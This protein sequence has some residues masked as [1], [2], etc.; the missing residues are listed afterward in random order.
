MKTLK[1]NQRTALS[2]SALMILISASLAAAP[3]QAGI[4]FGVRVDTPVVKARYHS[5]HGSRI[6]V[7]VPSYDYRVQ[8]TKFDRKVARK[9]ARRTDYNKRELLRLKRAGYNWREIG[10]MLHLPRKMVR[11]VIRNVRISMSS[12]GDRYGDYGYWDDD[13]WDNDRRGGRRPKGWCGT[14]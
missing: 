3:A 13:R 9:L 7:R 6:H 14:R 11:R 10:R 12:H 4:K 8:I 5:G 1:L 2:L